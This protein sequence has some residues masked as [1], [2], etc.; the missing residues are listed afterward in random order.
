[1]FTAQTTK[2]MN[3]KKNILLYMHFHDYRHKMW[4][5]D[6]IIFCRPQMILCVRPKIQ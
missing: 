4:V 3:T 2:I 5:L 6:I 1:M